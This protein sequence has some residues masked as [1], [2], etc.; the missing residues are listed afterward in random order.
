MSIF[1]SFLV[2]AAF[3]PGDSSSSYVSYGHAARNGIEADVIGLDFE[4]EILWVG[5]AGR[6]MTLCDPGES[7]FCFDAPA[8]SFSVPK[9]KLKIGDNWETNGFVYNVDRTQVISA[10]GVSIDCLVVVSSQKGRE[11]HFFYSSDRGL[12]AMWLSSTKKEEAS[13][14]L[15]E[16]GRGF[17][18]HDQRP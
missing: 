6:G 3:V 1:T 18:Y 11:I 16:Q 10:L 12:I 9:K 5:H 17:P 4:K 8:L 13:F 15:S 14:F 2:L 7:F